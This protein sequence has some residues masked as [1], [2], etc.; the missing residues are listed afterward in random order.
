MS[1]STVYF[2]FLCVSGL[3]RPKKSFSCE[4]WRKDMKQQL[5]DGLSYPLA[6]LPG[7]RQSFGLTQPQISL[8]FLLDSSASCACFTLAS[9]GHSDHHGHCQWKLTQGLVD[10]LNPALSCRYL[11]AGNILVDARYLL[12]LSFALG[13]GQVTCKL[14]VLLLNFVRQDRKTFRKKINF[15]LLRE[16]TSKNFT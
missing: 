7:L 2:S 9:E 1:A 13:C 15:S 3:S 16:H 5:S 4:I 10:L 6:C 11:F 14:Q 12:L 8:T